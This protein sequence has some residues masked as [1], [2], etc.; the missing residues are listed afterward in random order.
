MMPR[1]RMMANYGY[2]GTETDLGEV[3]AATEGEAHGRAWE[4]AIERV[5]CCVE[6][7]EDEE[8]QSDG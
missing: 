4:A 6:E 5:D 8:G 1:Y 7:V 2:A 3:E